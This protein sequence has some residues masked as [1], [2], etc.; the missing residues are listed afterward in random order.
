MRI[1]FNRSRENGIY[2]ENFKRGLGC[3]EGASIVKKEIFR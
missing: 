3:Q 2:E 1:K